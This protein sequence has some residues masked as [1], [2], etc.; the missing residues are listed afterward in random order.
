MVDAAVRAIPSAAASHGI[1]TPQ[2]L[3]SRF[4]AMRSAVLHL[5]H[6]PLSPMT[7][8]SDG[9]G[10]EAG[11]GSGRGGILAHAAARVASWLKVEESGVVR[12]LGPDVAIARGGVDAAVAAAE[13][14]I[15]AGRLARAA[16]ILRDATRGT[17]AAAAVGAWC[18]EARARAVADQSL[19]LLRAHAT[20]LAASLV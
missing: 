9:V 8:P 15:A 10:E 5:S 1:A 2:E 20:S 3:S 16:E 7:P 19:K 13:A 6:L 4:R 12:A 18:E 17:A 14:E 11:S